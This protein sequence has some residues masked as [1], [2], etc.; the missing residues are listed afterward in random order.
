MKK[1][2]LL[3]SARIKTIKSFCL[4]DAPQF[5]MS[6]GNRQIRKWK[7][8]EM[9]I[10]IDFH[11]PLKR[12]FRFE[13]NKINEIFLRPSVEP[14]C[15]IP[16]KHEWTSI[17]WRMCFTRKRWRQGMMNLLLIRQVSN[18]IDTLDPYSVDLSRTEQTRDF[19]TFFSEKFR[20]WITFTAGRGL[21]I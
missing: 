2:A 10:V 15:A 18:S 20:D 3:P 19:V 21:E 14:W 12:D 5:V 11:F 16:M 7:W 8:G 6:G 17:V 1:F 13:E 4:G 9:G